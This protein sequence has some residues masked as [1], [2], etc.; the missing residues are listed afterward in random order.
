MKNV[1]KLAAGILALCCALTVS[2]PTW[3]VSEDELAISNALNIANLSQNATISYANYTITGTSDPAQELTMNGEPVENRGSSGTFGV[4][5]ALEY[6]ENVFTFRQGNESKTVTVT[7]PKSTGSTAS[8]KAIDYITQSSMFPANTALARPGDTVSLACVAPSTATVQ[9]EVN[10]KTVTLKQ[11]AATAMAGIPATFT[12]S[13]TI[14]DNGSFAEDEVESLGKIR[15]TLS[16]NGTE[17]EYSST[18]KLFV[19][20]AE[21]SPML[22]VSDDYANVYASSSGSTNIIGTFQQGVKDYIAEEDGGYFKLASTRGWV[23]KSV[24]ELVTGS[25]PALQS[26]SGVIYKVGEKSESYIIKD[27]KDVPYSYLRGEG[28]FSMTL[29][30]VTGMPSLNAKHSK[31][32][33]AVSK[34]EKDGAVT[35]TFK[36]KEGKSIWGYNV[37]KTAEGTRLYFHYAPEKGTASKPLANVTVVVDPGHGGKDPGAIGAAGSFG[38]DEADLNLALAQSVKEELEAL[39]A[40]V[41][42]TRSDDS[43]FLLTERRSFTAQY[44]PDFF[45]S[46]HHNSVG[47]NVDALKVSGAE[48]YYYTTQSH[49]YAG[50]VLEGL[51]N[52]IGRNNRGVKWNGFYVNRMTFMPAILLESGFITNPVEYDQCA[53]ADSIQRAAEGIAQGVA[54]SLN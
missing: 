50:R 9:V 41:Y 14:P 35:Y 28:E 7:R 24:V 4:Y 39:G 23:H 22:V 15:Y 52:A 8:P 30:N 26:P 54:K 51:T 3:A 11:K 49:A 34:K 13:Y 31:L 42:L 27:V 53:D 17:K 16:Y 2:A 29:Y 6:G 44:R 36:L 12:G 19:A 1:K 47:Y 38:P 10:G 40:T 21:A 25:E 43:D 18:G 5:V 37:E 48:V 46:V 20:G 45:L 32:F 33:D